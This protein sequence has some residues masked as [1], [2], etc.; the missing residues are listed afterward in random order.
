L[1]SGWQVWH[2]RL[3][4]GADEEI[5]GLCLRWIDDLW[6]CNKGSMCATRGEVVRLYLKVGDMV[7]TVSLNYE[8]RGRLTAE[9]M[10]L[11]ELSR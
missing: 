4:N 3:T 9:R 5:S 2:I 10:I 7:V 11:A 1:R 8:M 6:G